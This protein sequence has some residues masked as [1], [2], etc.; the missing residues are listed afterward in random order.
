[1]LP[2]NRSREDGQ[3]GQESPSSHTHKSDPDRSGSPIQIQ[4]DRRRF[5]ADCTRHPVRFFSAG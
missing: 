2:A 4:G 3:A 1:M 5:R